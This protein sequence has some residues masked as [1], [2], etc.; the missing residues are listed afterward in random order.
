MRNTKNHNVNAGK[1]PFITTSKKCEKPNFNNVQQSVWWRLYNSLQELTKVFFI[2]FY[3]LKLAS[4]TQFEINKLRKHFQFDWDSKHRNCQDASGQSSKSLLNFESQWPLS[5]RPLG[6]FPLSTAASASLW[7]LVYLDFPLHCSTPTCSSPTA[8]L[9]L[10]PVFI[11]FFHK[12]QQNRG[13]A[14]WP[15]AGGATQPPTLSMNFS[16]SPSPSVVDKQ[17]LASAAAGVM[18][19]TEGG[20]LRGENIV[21][22]WHRS[23]L[24]LA[25]W[26]HQAL[27]L[28]QSVWPRGLCQGCC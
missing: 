21:Q 14:A 25:E 9:H 23:N 1:L 3:L 6:G 5:P 17:S 26:F 19:L 2:F 7:G 22:Q 4:C 18:A 20:M 8:H 15:P 27:L 13:W 11:N 16:S 12:A 28:P 24:G 10:Q